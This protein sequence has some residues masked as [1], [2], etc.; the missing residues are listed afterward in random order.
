MCRN[1]RFRGLRWLLFLTALSCL[2]KTMFGTATAWSVAFFFVS[3]AL[4]YWLT[5]KRTRKLDALKTR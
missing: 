3:G 5:W 2:L 4:W 1:M